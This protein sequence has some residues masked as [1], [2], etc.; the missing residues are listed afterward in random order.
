[1]LWVYLPAAVLWIAGA[2]RLTVGAIIGHHPQV[3]PGGNLLVLGIPP[4][5][6]AWWGV[7]ET[8]FLLVLAVCWLGSVAGQVLSYRRSSGVRRQ[9]LKWLMAGSA[10]AVAAAWDLPS[11]HGELLRPGGGIIVAGAV[12]RS[13]CAS[14]WPC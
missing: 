2:H 4:R 1:M 10:I 5:S 9:Q 6:P 11:R 7:V 12:R 3:D 8:V 14:G 13:R